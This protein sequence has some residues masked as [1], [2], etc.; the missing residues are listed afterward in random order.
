VVSFVGAVMKLW[1]KEE[2]ARLLECAAQ[3]KP[4]TRCVEDFPGRTVSSLYKRLRRL[5]K[6]KTRVKG[7]LPFRAGD[8]MRLLTENGPM[9]ARDIAESL[10]LKLSGVHRL[11]REMRAEKKAHIKDRVL[12]HGTNRALLWAAGEGV[13]APQL[14][15][16]PKTAQSKP[17][18]K[19][20]A[21]MSI[22]KTADE[23]PRQPTQVIV[24][25]DPF[26][27]AL[28]GERAAA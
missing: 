12:V 27:A 14:A 21:P 3:I 4:M 15:R 28:F 9:F 20:T 1:T 8:V 25:R 19:K 13:D 5:K 24:R 22:V 7:R 6:P 23:M 2:E 10:D 11:L 17:M 16:R 18:V 26:I